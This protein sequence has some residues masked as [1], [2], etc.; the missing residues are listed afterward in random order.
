M[1]PA[2]WPPGAP[3]P[4]L[5]PA[6]PAALPAGS[7]VGGVAQLVVD[8]AAQTLETPLHHGQRRTA[9][10]AQKQTAACQ[11]RHDRGMN[12][13]GSPLVTPEALEAFT[14]RL[15]AHYSPEKVILFGSLARGE[16]RWDSDADLLVVMPFEGRHPNKTRELRKRCRADFTPDPVLWRPDQAAARYPLGVPLRAYPLDIGTCSQGCPSTERVG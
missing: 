12:A 10:E 15:V 1:Q 14:K 8:K 11:A 16:A 6:T 13:P 2:G 9:A 5:R 7:A 3:R 4:G